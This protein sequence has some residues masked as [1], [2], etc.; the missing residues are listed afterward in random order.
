M[1]YIVVSMLYIRCIL[2]CIYV[3][4]CCMMYVETCQSIA[5]RHFSP[6]LSGQV[7]SHSGLNRAGCI[8]P[9]YALSQWSKMGDLNHF[10]TLALRVPKIE[11]PSVRSCVRVCLE[12]TGGE[13]GNTGSQTQN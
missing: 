4:Y 2:N 5:D 10:R 13:G 7:S 1:L 12:V 8:M 9:S 3:V 6:Q 11:I